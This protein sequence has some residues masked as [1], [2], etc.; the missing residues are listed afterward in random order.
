MRDKNKI[1]TLVLA[2]WLGG[3]ALVCAQEPATSPKADRPAR[4]FLSALTHNLG[5]DLKHVP[6]R[7]SLY[8][9]A[10]G[11]AG[12]LLIH[13]E[14]GKINR[15]LTGSPT[16]DSIVTP[17]KYVGNTGVVLGAAAATYAVGRFTH[18]PRVQHLGMDEI[19]AALLAEGIS[20]G[21]KVIV[22]RDRP[23]STTGAQSSGFSF[24][25]GHATVTFAAATVLQQHLGYKA[26]IPTYLAA[27]Y[28][29]MSRLHD[30]RHYAS[31]VIFGAATGIIIGRSVTFHGRNYWSGPMLVPANRGF[32]I[33]FTRR[34]PPG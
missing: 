26:G 29:A 32:A 10:A 13:P 8:W 2:G 15:R 16:F 11:G 27:S 19:E 23:I 5:D 28:V 30:N 14:D 18:A 1:A 31:D 24:P 4:G 22:R 21:I 3:S 25:S 20:Q 34:P 17:G 12:A 6:R 9:L 33:V 7:N